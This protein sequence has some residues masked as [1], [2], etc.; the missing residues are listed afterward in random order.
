[1]KISQER[2]GYLAGL[3]DRM[4]QLN[5]SE[6]IDPAALKEF[7]RHVCI[8]I[9]KHHEREEA[10]TGLERQIKKVKTISLAKNPKRW[11]I[12]KELKVLNNKISLAL[13]K[14][15]KLLGMGEKDSAVILELKNKIQQLERELI[16]KERSETEGLTKNKEKIE[17]MDYTLKALKSKIEEIAVVK[18]E[19]EKRI[20]EL[21]R[22][23]KGAPPTA[24]QKTL[25]LRGQIKA[26]EEK[27]NKMRSRYS[28][29]DLKR[30]EGKIGFLKER[31][32]DL[33]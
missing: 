15:S 3:E 27:Y 9:K 31:L 16:E 29:E 25:L 21:E 24:T 17:E 7:V 26:L 8:V 32:A 1:M 22:R 33:G 19:R 20:K 23:I 6:H 12:E 4:E 14:E 18:V 2:K 30:V 5:S 11:L 28:R 10:R 13:E